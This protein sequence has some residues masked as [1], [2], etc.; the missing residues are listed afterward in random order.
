MKSGAILWK[1]V[2]LLSFVII[3]DEAN[4]ICSGI[5]NDLKIFFNFEIDSKDRAVLL[6]GLP[7][8]NNMLRLS[9]HEPLRQC[10]TMNYNIDG[11]TRK[12]SKQ[13]I[14][15]K[16]NGAG[17]SRTVF[18]ENALEALANASNGV[19][20]VLNKLCNSCLMIG[21]SRMAK[22]IDE[23]TVMQ[24]VNDCEFG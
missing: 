5:L 19:P 16:L 10:I 1:S 20:R 7:P 11:I 4:H 18:N 15:R 12:E 17:C 13:Y 3:I 2:L 22:V 23:E 24:A 8:L 6:A 14:L 21:N 9:I